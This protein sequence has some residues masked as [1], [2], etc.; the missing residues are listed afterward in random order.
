MKRRANS[1]ENAIIDEVLKL[2]KIMFGCSD[3]N[4]TSKYSEL[5]QQDTTPL[6]WTST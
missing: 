1:S 2:K 3:Q 6:P 4:I 5:E